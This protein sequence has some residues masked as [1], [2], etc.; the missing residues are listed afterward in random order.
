MVKIVLVSI[1]IWEIDRFG[2]FWVNR[3][4]NYTDQYKNLRNWQIWSRG[5]YTSKHLIILPEWP[6][7]P[8]N[9]SRNVKKNLNGEREWGGEEWKPQN[10]VILLSWFWDGI[11]GLCII[12]VKSVYSEISAFSKKIFHFSCMNSRK[13]FSW[14]RCAPRLSEDF[15]GNPARKVEDFFWKCT[16]LR[17]YYWLYFCRWSVQ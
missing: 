12:L 7:G 2:D 11:L 17:I 1:R 6:S 10:Q 3:G 8:N 5:E 16:D 14:P 15:T 13:I 4:G 9:S